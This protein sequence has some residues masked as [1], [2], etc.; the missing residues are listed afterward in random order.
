MSPR[1]QRRALVGLAV[2]A[3]FSEF[4]KRYGASRLTEELN[5]QGIEC[6]VNHVAELLRERG[7]ESEKWQGVQVLPENGIKDEC[8]R[9]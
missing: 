7:A 4:K 3:T 9:Q 5:A 1:S 6:S 2:E 8:R